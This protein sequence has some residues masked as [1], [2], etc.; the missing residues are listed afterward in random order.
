MKALMESLVDSQVLF[1]SDPF[2]FHS[3]CELPAPPW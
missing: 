3:F 2:G 1:I